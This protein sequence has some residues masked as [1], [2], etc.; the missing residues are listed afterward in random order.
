MW[1]FILA[2]FVIVAIP[3]PGQA[4]ITRNSLA[5]GRRAGIATMLGGASG[6]GVHATAAASG[7]SAILAASAAAFT[8]VK[9]VGVAYLSI[10]HV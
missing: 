4:L 1:S 8:V 9:L 2:S 10:W 5:G 6:I 3:G 7:L